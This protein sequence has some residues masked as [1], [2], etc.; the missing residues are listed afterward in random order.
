VFDKNSSELLE[1]IRQ[2]FD[3]GPYPR[4]PLEK[5]P[6]DQAD[7]LYIHNLVTPYY[8]RNQKI[9]KTE[10]K[11][12]LDAGCG[13][14]YKSLALAIAN[15]GAKIIGI[16]LSEE[17][18]K[19]ARER[20][21]YHN[22]TNVDFYPLSI[23][24]LP[25]LR[26]EFDYINC[27][28]VLYLLPDIILGLQGM[29][30]VLKPDGIIRT[31]LHSLLQRFY[32]YRAQELYKM[33]GLMDE[34]P[35]EMEIEL[36][37]EMMGALK[38]NVVLKKITWQ[39]QFEKSEQA[40]LANHFLQGDR[41]HT[42]PEMFSALKA[43]ELEFISMVNWWQW[44]LMDLFKDPENLPV[45]LA[46]S[47]PEISSEEQM[48]IYELLNPVHRLFDFWC[49]HPNQSQPFTPVDEWTPSDWQNAQVHLHPQLKTPAMK[50]ELL[51]CIKQL[52]PFE[53]SK[54]LPFTGHSNVVDSSIAACILLPLLE[55][56][57]SL[58][59][60]VE[61]WQKL[62]PVNPVTSEPTTQ[63]EAFEIITQAMLGLETFSY[64]LLERHS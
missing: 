56:A 42:I 18:V 39:P 23:E 36:L 57:Q 8:L 34:N 59:S 5:S 32:Y 61:R 38:D 60:F 41:G 44:D 17:S 55:S 37:R 58:A 1:K 24:E 25:Q 6:K 54:Q 50:E 20:L 26:I 7:F 47:L 64:V 52:H 28:E 63:E 29:K 40:I 46:I 49:G 9:I 43:A 21:Q 11:V 12:I 35:Q 15:P 53:L 27:D 48:H 4:I 62:R 16:D 45:F 13:S 30:S 3:T 51:R 10:G 2:Q 14:G 31:N 33:M 19:L 22:L